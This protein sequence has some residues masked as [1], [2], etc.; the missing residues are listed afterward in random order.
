MAVKGDGASRLVGRQ[1]QQ[2]VLAGLIS[3]ARNGVSG[4]MLIRGDPGIG[5]T[6][7]LQDVTSRAAGVDLVQLIG[8]EAESSIPFSALQRLLPALARHLDGCP[9]GI[10]RRC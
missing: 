9:T 3:N 1:E 4:S 10:G 6:S 7:L 5:K 2:R 8:F